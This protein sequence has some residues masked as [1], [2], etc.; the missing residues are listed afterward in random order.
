MGVLYAGQG[1]C[2]SKFSYQSIFSFFF[3]PAGRDTFSSAGK[4][5][6]SLF[7]WYFSLATQRKVH[8]RLGKQEKVPRHQGEIGSKKM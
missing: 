8:E 3:R 1:V 7:F 5:S 6:G 2:V 4:P